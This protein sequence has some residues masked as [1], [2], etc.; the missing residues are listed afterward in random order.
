MKPG[1]NNE[2]VYRMAFA[3]VY[4]HYVNKVERKGRTQAKAMR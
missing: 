3:S 4:P 1:S 2:R